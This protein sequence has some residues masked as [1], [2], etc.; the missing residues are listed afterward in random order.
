MYPKNYIFSETTTHFP[1]HVIYI[2]IYICYYH[3]EIYACVI[4]HHVFSS[5]TVLK[6][7]IESYKSYFAIKYCVNY[8]YDPHMNLCYVFIYM[9]SP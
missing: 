8:H 2:Y 6:H 5:E 1:I 9:V 3:M 7:D 4:F